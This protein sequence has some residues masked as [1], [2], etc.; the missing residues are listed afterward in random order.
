MGRR[1]LLIH[2]PTPAFPVF[3]LCS[4]STRM[5]EGLIFEELSSDRLFSLDLDMLC[6]LDDVCLTFS[7][8]LAALFIN[9]SK[10]VVGFDEAFQPIDRST[11]SHGAEEGPFVSEPSRATGMH[12]FTHHQATVPRVNTTVPDDQYPSPN[13]AAPIPEYLQVSVDGLVSQLER[14]VALQVKSIT[15]LKCVQPSPRRNRSYYCPEST[16]ARRA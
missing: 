8:H 16:T 7:F 4:V 13:L 10:P 1:S 2:K 14:S 15:S 12:W 9:G 6:T 5:P 11:V 3:I